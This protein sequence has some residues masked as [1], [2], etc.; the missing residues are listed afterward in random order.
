[1]ELFC[2]A[3]NTNT[4]QR[5]AVIKNGAAWPFQRPRF[6]QTWRFTVK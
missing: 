5:F 6:L 1:V 2:D 3:L 4:I